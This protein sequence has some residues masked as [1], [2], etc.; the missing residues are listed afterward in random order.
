MKRYA[1]ACSYLALGATVLPALLFFA[2]KVS[3][4]QAK[5][6]MLLATALWFVSAPLW[7]EHQAGE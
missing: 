1:Q 5:L 3:L 6:W 2:D 7:M 4:P